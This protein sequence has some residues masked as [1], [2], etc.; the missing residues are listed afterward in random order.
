MSDPQPFGTMMQLGEPIE[1]DGGLLGYP[2]DLVLLSGEE[3]YRS[4]FDGRFVVDLDSIL[5]EKRDYIGDYNHNEDEVIGRGTLEVTDRGLIGRCFVIPFT[6]NDRA[7]EIIARSKAKIPYEA[8]PTISDDVADVEK[9]P[10]G[11]KVNVNGREFI[12]PISVYRNVP[13]R[14]WS[15]CLFGTDRKTSFQVLKKMK[16]KK[17][18][19]SEEKTD[20]TEENKDGYTAYPD[21]EKM[22]EIFG[23]EKGVEYYRK[24]LT[25]EEAE[26][27]DYEELK[28]TRKLEEEK[29]EKS[30]LDTPPTPPKEEDATLKSDTSGL[31]AKINELQ[32]SVKKMFATIHGKLGEEP[33][34]Q[35][36]EDDPHRKDTGIQG[37][38]MSAAET[39]ALKKIQSMKK[40]G[41]K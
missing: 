5:L 19:D 26:K 31:V 28:A 35:S 6:G 3:L 37:L 24:G 21:L 41:K 23:F 39:Y 1:L 9:I 15:V 10:K 38:K 30:E 18:S 20:Q 29:E 33:L 27:L 7:S 8:S 14:G 34:T 22:I 4:D 17:M 32:A 16:G 13:I 36:H 12:G 11:Q 40:L 25:I 2:A